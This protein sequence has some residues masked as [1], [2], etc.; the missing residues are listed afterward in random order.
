MA[1][2][3]PLV[4]W[5]CIF[6][7]LSNDPEP[8]MHS[9]EVPHLDRTDAMDWIWMGEDTPSNLFGSHGLADQLWEEWRGRKMDEILANQLLGSVAAKADPDPANAGP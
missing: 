3:V 8:D 5:D 6:P 4:L 2:E 7:D 9:A 1:D